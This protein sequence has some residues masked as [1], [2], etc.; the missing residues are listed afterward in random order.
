MSFFGKSR[1]AGDSNDAVAVTLLDTKLRSRELSEIALRSAEAEFSNG[2]ARAFSNSWTL[3]VVEF[4]ALAFWGIVS[5]AAYHRTEIYETAYVA[6]LAATGILVATIYCTARRMFRLP[7]STAFRRKLQS[8]LQAIAIWCASFLVLSFFSF[9]FRLNHEFSRGAVLTF[10]FTGL[11]FLYFLRR[12]ATRLF[13]KHLYQ[14]SMRWSDAVIIGCSAESVKMVG[15]NMTAQG[16]MAPS[17]VQIDVLCDATAWPIELQ[18]AIART[19]SFAHR[20][21]R[22]AIYVCAEDFPKDR[23][24]MLLDGLRVIP[25]SVRIVPDAVTRDI[26]SLHLRNEIGGITLEVQSSPLTVGQRALKR[27]FDLATSLLIVLLLLPLIAVIALAIKLD[28]IGPV[29]FRQTRLGYR[30]RPFKIF[31]FRTMSVL[32]DG[33]IILQARKNDPRVTRVGRFL[34]RS[35]LDEILQLMNVIRGEMSLVGPRPHAVAHDKMYSGLIENYDLRQHVLP[36]MTGWAQVHGFHG[37]TPSEDTM[38]RRLELDLW[39]T[40]NASLALDTEIILRTIAV[41]FA[42]EPEDE[43]NHA[44]IYQLYQG[45]FEELVTVLS[46]DGPGS[47]LVV[48]PNV[49][50]YRL[51]GRS[52]SF[53]RAYKSA[54][55]IIND[56]RV[57]DGFFLNGSV[58]CAP[59]ADFVPELIRALRPG[60]KLCVVGHTG[61][62]QKILESRFPDLKLSFIQPSMGYIKKRRERQLLLDDINKISPDLVFVCTGA[63]QSEIFSAHLKSRLNS[64]AT[65]VCCGSALE[66]LCGSKRRA[67]AAVRYMRL[68]WMWRFIWEPHTRLRYTADAL[69]L[70]RSMFSFMNFRFGASA[71]LKGFSIVRK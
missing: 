34:R 28:S 43:Q 68:E 54:D 18:H 26:L 5:G 61:A 30:G 2:S 16:C 51:L 45:E 55:Y 53:R 13:S 33:P 6:E 7:N 65:I 64:N 21:H 32:E 63:P 56:S 3:F 40:K 70:M 69:Y 19:I 42:Q 20:A 50:H 59:G 60:K 48:T 24:Q 31:K 29:I 58:L 36:G 49:D 14:N 37:E 23:L 15:R 11:P 39:Y 12:L 57:L 66:F 17:T 4:F 9:A 8:F 46:N 27:G 41:I 62:V 44:T 25:R 10:F 38:R 71:K 22:G 47:R 35:H 67:P 52:A 1:S